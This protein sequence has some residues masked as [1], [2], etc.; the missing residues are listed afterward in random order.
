MIKQSLGFPK[1]LMLESWRTSRMKM[2]R[3]LVDFFVNFSPAGTTG[4]RFILLAVWKKIWGSH[5][6][7]CRIATF[8]TQQVEKSDQL[9]TNLVQDVHSSL[10]LTD[11][12][13][14]I[15]VNH[16]LDHWSLFSFVKVPGS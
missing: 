1:A 16:F 9:C 7:R 10:L 8:N 2:W 5:D 6:D 12:G 13:Y 3:T 11:I 4:P 14:Q 15:I